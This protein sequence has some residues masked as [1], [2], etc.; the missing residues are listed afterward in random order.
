LTLVMLRLTSSLC[1]PYAPALASASCAL[2]AFSLGVAPRT[3]DC[4]VSNPFQPLTLRHPEDAEG[5]GHGALSLLFRLHGGHPVPFCL[6]GSPAAVTISPR[7]F[8]GGGAVTL[9]G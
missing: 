8:H 2:P 5:D 1:T 3:T 9:G 7:R 4:R 6:I